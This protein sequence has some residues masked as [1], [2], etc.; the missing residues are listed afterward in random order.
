MEKALLVVVN[1]G[2][3][4][5]WSSEDSE[6]ELVELAKSSNVEVFECLVSPRTSPTPNFFIGKGKVYE[7][8]E[9]VKSNNIDV[10]IFDK[11]LSSAQQ[12]NL[13]EIIGVKTID[14]TQLILDIFSKRARS[15]EGKIQ[16]ELAQLVYLLPRLMGKGIML[17]RLGGGIGTRGPG[18]K[19]LEVDR[20]RIREKISSLKE[21]LLGI[22]KE[23]S[24]RRRTRI[25]FSIPT[26]SLV[27][28]TNAGKSTLFNLL[29]GSDELVLGKLFSTLD[30]TTRRISLPNK[31]KA[32]LSDTV[33]FLHDLPHHLIE[34][35]KA[36]LEEVVHADLLIHVVDVSHPMVYEHFMSVEKVLAE[37]G[38]DNK[39]KIIALNK[40]D[41]LTSTADI[42]RFEES[43]NNSVP[44]SALH[45]LGINS[46]LKEIELFFSDEIVD[47][48][49]TIPYS[50]MKLIDLIYKEG[51]VTKRVD[52]AKGIALHAQ[53]TKRVK[54]ILENKLGSS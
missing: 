2:K 45:N 39:A 29:T 10:V 28:Y 23:R 26:I 37:I 13:E 31:Q 32:V 43:F 4:S 51:V 35:F 52:E 48:K 8:A 22:E 14:R 25:K 15:N 18:E 30:P 33:G 12:R 50:K 46:L 36:T 9:F 38:V 53:V 24:L 54:S 40:I 34:S 21:D 42:K 44:I 47:I 7:I 5:G 6:S 19:K 41:K 27:G 1:F 20:R 3:K 49:L 11:D 17:S 16:V